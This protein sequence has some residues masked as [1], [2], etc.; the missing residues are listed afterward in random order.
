[1]AITAISGE[2]VV[3]NIYPYHNTHYNEV[4]SVPVEPVQRTTEVAGLSSE[5]EQVQ[6]GVTYEPFKG[7]IS[8]IE[9]NAVVNQTR[10]LKEAFQ[11]GEDLYYDQ[12]NP[13]EMARMSV[14]GMLLTGMNIDFM[15]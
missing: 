13:Y 8:Q 11:Q 6:L 9:E 14:E 3:Q 2:R 10:Q 5:E 1:M 7:Q 12:S 4:A 15:A